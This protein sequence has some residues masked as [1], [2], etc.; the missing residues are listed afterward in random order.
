MGVSIGEAARQV[1]GL[2]GTHELAETL[3]LKNA[4]GVVGRSGLEL[5]ETQRFLGEVARAE[6][7]Y[8]IARW[9]GYAGS[10]EDFLGMYKGHLARHAEERWTLQDQDVADRLNQMA[11]DQGMGT[12]FSVGD[13]VTMAWT[14]GPEGQVERVSL[15]RGEAGA[16]REALDLTRS[17]RGIQDWSGRE[18]QHLNLVSGRGVIGLDQPGI[19]N[20]VTFAGLLRRSGADE[21]AR[22]LARDIGKGR[23][24]SLESAMFDPNNG[25]LVSF[26]LRRGGSNVVEDYSRTQTGWEKRTLALSTTQTGVISTAHDERRSIF[27]R[28][29]VT[30]PSSMWSSAIAGDETIGQRVLTAHTNAQKFQEMQE[31]AVKFAEAQAS[32][33]AI[34]GVL[35]SQAEYGAKGGIQGGISLWK[36]IGISAG[37]SA[38]VSGRNIEQDN[39]NRIYRDIRGAQDS[40][41]DK[42]NKGE[43]K[44]EEFVEQ[45][46]KT[47]QDFATEADRLV[48]EK[49]DE[50]FGAS[51]MVTRPFGSDK[52]GDIITGA[53]KAISEG[54]KGFKDWPDEGD[55]EPGLGP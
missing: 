16:E 18:A 48:K 31:Q 47:F 1:G 9:A 5:A 7:A 2:M 52:V 33:L 24:V 37:A 32:R 12:R 15:A 11:A 49:G 4:L 35:I 42:L 36:I 26:A 21:V 39:Y 23:Q 40:V 44:G 51:G 25:R 8:Q 19:F 10:R 14:F 46:T 43:I 55:K 41:F 27:E 13:R 50:K 22:S 45:Y 34:E 3:G 6:Q 20:A 29:P 53:A 30:S 54:Q 38:G 28:G 17:I